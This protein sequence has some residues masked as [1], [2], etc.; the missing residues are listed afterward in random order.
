MSFDI[1][2]FINYLQTMEGGNKDILPAKATAAHV[3]GF[4]RYTP[5][6][7]PAYKALMCYQSLQNYFN[8]LKSTMKFSATTI[9]EKLRAIR[10]AI[11][12]VSYVNEHDQEVISRGQTVKDRL[13][14]WGKALTKDIK[15]Q[16]NENLIKAS[17][18]V[19]VI[20]HFI[21]FHTLV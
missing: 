1:E 10:Q 19:S 4:F 12:Y 15:R 16:R 13:K 21:K 11:E 8:H 18:E 7:Q 6:T 5:E 20:S 3:R 17:Y 2:G 9:A 14:I